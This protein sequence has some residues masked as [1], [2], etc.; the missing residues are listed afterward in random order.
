MEL[1]TYDFLYLANGKIALA[2]GAAQ[3]GASGFFF[4]IAGLDSRCRLLLLLQAA[5][6]RGMLQRVGNPYIH[7]PHPREREG[8]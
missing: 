1:N 4:L 2:E 8:P 5:G 7:Y 3:V 6:F